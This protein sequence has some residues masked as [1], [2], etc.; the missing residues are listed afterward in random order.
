MKLTCSKNG[1]FFIGTP[2]NG[3]I[4]STDDGLTWTGIS[5]GLT[6]YSIYSFAFGDSAKVFTSSYDSAVYSSTNNGDSWKPIPIPNYNDVYSLATYNGE[7]FAGTTWGVYITDYNKI[8]WEIKNNDLTNASVSVLLFNSYGHL[9][10]GTYGGI[11]RSTDMGESWLNISSGLTDTNITCMTFSPDGFIYAGTQSGSVF[12]SI[13]PMTAVIQIKSNIPVA[14]ELKQNFPNPFNP[15]TTINYSIPQSGFVTIK[16]YDI[17]GRQVATLVN[18]NKPAGNYS[19]KFD[20]S[21]LV[22]GVYFYRME[23]GSFS[24][25]KKLLLLK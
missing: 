1:D 11:Y 21:K 5:S 17:L 22:S 2:V 13:N 20:G 24:Q 16:L 3:A 12:K 19:A 25:T 15:A 23:A 10:A 18:D 6:Q 9:Y 4:R 7:L 8:N 14:F